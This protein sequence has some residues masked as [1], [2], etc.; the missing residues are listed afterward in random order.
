MTV[1]QLLDS[2]TSEELNEWMALYRLEH[3]LANPA[4]SVEDQLR[5]AFGAK[6]R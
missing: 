1:R 4:G 5:N 3:E 2:T 6:K